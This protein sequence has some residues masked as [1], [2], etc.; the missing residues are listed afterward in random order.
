M[1]TDKQYKKES[2]MTINNNKMNNEYKKYE[3]IRD[4]LNK[5]IDKYGVNETIDAMAESIVWI[6][7]DDSIELIKERLDIFYEISEEIENE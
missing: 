1:K 3:E 6:T 2:I 4:E 5:L 7:E